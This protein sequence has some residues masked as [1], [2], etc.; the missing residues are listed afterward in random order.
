MAYKNDSAVSIF[1]HE[2]GRTEV[3]ADRMI[4]K[5]YG[6]TLRTAPDMYACLNT[7]TVYDCTG[8]CLKT[9]NCNCS[10][11]GN[12]VENNLGVTLDMS[13]G[14]LIRQRILLNNGHYIPEN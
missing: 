4:V 11:V 14:Q 6:D 8:G 5:R 3:L 13:F 2:N 7:C 9:A 12:C 1:M 10:C